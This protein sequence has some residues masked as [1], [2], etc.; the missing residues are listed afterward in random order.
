MSK[1]SC[2][3]SIFIVGYVLFLDKYLVTRS[4]WARV[5]GG[6][7][8]DICA[9][10]YPDIIEELR[11]RVRTTRHVRD[12]RPNAHFNRFIRVQIQVEVDGGTHE[13]E[14]G[15]VAAGCR[16]SAPVTKRHAGVRTFNPEAVCG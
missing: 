2:A 7:A 15:A 8:R 5:A 12:G 11:A 3:P 1:K 9:S 16:V 13:L 6:L 10:L 4:T 14:H